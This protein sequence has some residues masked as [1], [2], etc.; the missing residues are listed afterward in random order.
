MKKLIIA[1]TFIL[2]FMSVPKAYATEAELRA[3]RPLSVNLA[4][5]A[6]IFFAMTQAPEV[7]KGPPKQCTTL[8]KTAF[9]FQKGAQAQAKS[10]GQEKYELYVDEHIRQTLGK[11]KEKSYDMSSKSETQEWVKYCVTTGAEVGLITTQPKKK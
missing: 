2:C 3:A 1:L 10:E 7:I 9:L 4:E 11:W 6:V 5:C 8:Q